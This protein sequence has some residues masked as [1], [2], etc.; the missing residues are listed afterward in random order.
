M[1]E[2]RLL[3]KALLIACMKLGYAEDEIAEMQGYEEQIDSEEEHQLM[4][5]HKRSTRPMKMVRKMLEIAKTDR[6]ER[7][8]S[9]NLNYWDSRLESAKEW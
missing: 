9:T 8:L 2:I 6:Y 5:I 1:D 7:E 3:R 4:C